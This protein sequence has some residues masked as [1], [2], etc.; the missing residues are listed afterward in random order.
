M[1]SRVHIE[2]FK[3][4]LLFAGVIYFLHVMA[5][6]VFQKY[7]G[8]PTPIGRLW[9]S[10]NKFLIKLSWVNKKE[11]GVKYCEYSVYISLLKHR[12]DNWISRGFWQLTTKYQQG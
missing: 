3:D 6:L 9:L 5:V 4:F 8:S 12:L 11:F 7:G 1:H 10:E 2:V